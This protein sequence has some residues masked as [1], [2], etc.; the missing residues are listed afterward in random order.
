MSATL[1]NKDI[2]YLGLDKRRV[3][4]ISC[5]S[6]ILAERR[7]VY[8]EPIGSMASHSQTRNLDN[9]VAGIE[10]VLRRHERQKGLIHVT[11][12]LA[13]KLRPLLANNPRLIW[14]TKE[15]KKK[16]YS[17]FRASRPEEGK[18]LMASGLYEVVDL[19]SDAGRFQVIAKI[20]WPSL[21]DPVTSYLTEKDQ[22]YYSWETIKIVLQACGRICRKLDDWGI[23]YILDSTFER[24]YTKNRSMF[25]EY[26]RE[27]L[28]G[29]E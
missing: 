9:L 20:P 15:D 13:A 14:H 6:P 22:E 4:T 7:P 27:S 2:E 8:Y 10:E 1:S 3:C 19:P 21:G 23:T 29:I 28:K 18:V 17:K 11:Y 24:L 26:F 12:S 25:P 5:S 16:Q